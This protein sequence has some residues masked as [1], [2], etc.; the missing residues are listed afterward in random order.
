MFDANKF[1]HAAF[2]AKFEANILALQGAE[3]ITKASLMVL[4][5]DVL[6]CLHTTEDVR[7]VNAVINSLTPVNK[8]VAVLF[9]QH[10]TG[11]KFDDTT[12]N[13][14]SKNKAAYDAKRLLSASFL[15]DPLNN[16]WTWADREVVLTA[17]EFDIKE[18]TKA[19]ERFLKKAEKANLTQADVLRAV[20]AGGIN[21][22]T[23]MEILNAAT[24]AKQEADV[25]ADAA[26]L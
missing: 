17:K 23:L 6:E 24:E 18:V 26:Q 12:S 19:T 10:F 11:F 14:T 4:S 5:R 15:E 3:K 21:L 25:V 1:D 7:P 2:Q 22:D 16:I 8:K 13:F 9:F 20:L